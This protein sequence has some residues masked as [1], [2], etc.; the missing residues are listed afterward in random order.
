MNAAAVFDY[1]SQPKEWAPC[2][3]NLCG[4]RYRHDCGRRERVDRYGYEVGVV[5]CLCGLV[6]LYPRMTREAYAEFY[7]HHFRPLLSALYG[8]PFTAKTIQASQRCYAEPLVWFLSPHVKPGTLLDVGGSTGVVARRLAERFGL[9]ATVLDPAGDELLE[10]EGME[11][12]PALVEEWDPAGRTWDLIT[13]CQTVDHLLDIAGTLKKL[14]GCLAPGGHLFVDIA[15][16]NRRPT[17]K[18]DHPYYLT[19]K[20]IEAY[21]D[22]AGLRVV[23]VH[24]VKG[25][26][27]VRYLCQSR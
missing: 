15:D 21:F 8:E 5:E 26:Y 27:H 9:K 25:D 7:A 18:I 12:I 1:R 4:R 22:R 20:T 23:R 24:A 16:Y 13:L 14:K 17:L 10:A 3:C 6:F 19:P 2:V 11:R